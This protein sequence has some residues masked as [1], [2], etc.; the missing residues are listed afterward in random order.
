MEDTLILYIS[1]LER[2][3]LPAEG[4]ADLGPP[5]QPAPGST[6][7]PRDAA[8]DRL[9]GIALIGMLVHHLTEWTTG[10][11][12]SIMPGWTGFAVTDAAAVAFFVAAG[13]SSVLFIGSRR[14]RGLSPT[15][16][17]GQ[18][19]R[20]YVALVP[21][22]MTLGWFMWRDPFMVGVLEVLGVTVAVGA[23]VASVLPR[24]A[25]AP[26]AVLVLVVGMWSERWGDRQPGWFD[27]EVLSGKFP[28][29]TYLGFV[30]VGAAVVR[31]GWHTDRRRITFAALGL[32][33]VAVAMLV[34][35]AEPARYPGEWRYIVPG[36]AITAWVLALCRRPASL[37]SAGRAGPGVL[38]RVVRAAAAH[39]LG[40]YVGHYAVYG[41]LRH[42]DLRGG[43]HGPVA[44]PLVIAVT[45]AAC[46]VA[47]RVP[48]PPWSLRTGRRRQPSA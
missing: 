41:L 36:L 25:L 46:L 18:V 30:L 15:R 16:I 26:V 40:I 29:V 43:I 28:V 19:L 20:R 23:V 22:G 7:R 21:I 48:Q 17:A 8:L 44:V 32:T 4:G 3:E 10:D 27:A 33:V 47:P 1:V 11:A 9:R 2:E 38:D 6:P 34:A 45:V 12:R 13:A 31:M 24:V 14:R 42:F 35:G 5:P 37:R 39:T